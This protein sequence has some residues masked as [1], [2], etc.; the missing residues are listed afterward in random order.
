[1][2]DLPALPPA[3]RPGDAITAIDTP[4]LV[5][6]LDTSR[7]QAAWWHVDDVASIA[8]SAESLAS[9]RRMTSM[10]SSSAGG[11]FIEFEVAMNIVSHQAIA[12]RAYQ[13]HESCRDGDAVDNWLRAQRELLEN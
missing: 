1:M 10:R 12:R 6:D 13:I 4:A 5:L 2:A 11:M 7:A 3:A 8:G 9:A